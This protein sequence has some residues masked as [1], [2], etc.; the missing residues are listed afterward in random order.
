MLTDMI[1]FGAGKLAESLYEIASFMG[2]QIV[3][4]VDNDEGKWGKRIKG[5]E[6]VS[7]E[8][9]R[10]YSCKIV[11]PD[12]F[13]DVISLQLKK[14][15]YSGTVVRRSELYAEILTHEY[16]REQFRKPDINRHLTYVIDSYFRQSC[17][18]GAESWS[19]FVNNALVKK[20]CKTFFMCGNN[21]RF[22]NVVDDCVHYREDN[23]FEVMKKMID[24]I[25]GNLPCVIF[26]I[27]SIAI[28]AALIVKKLY[29][30]QIKIVMV[31]H[32][33][34]ERIYKN[35]SNMIEGIDKVICISKKIEE[36]CIRSYGIPADKLLYH[37]NPI[38]LAQKQPRKENM[39]GRLRVGFAARLTKLA[40]RTHLL[41]Q[42]V[43]ECFRRGL[44]VEF[45]IAGEGECLEQLQAYV[46]QN[47]LEEKVHLE[48]WVPPMSMIDF[49]R[50]QDIYISISDYEGMSLTMLEA[51]AY[52]AFP[53]VTE[54]SGVVDVVTDG[55]NGLII[56]VEKWL[57]CVDK[58]AVLDADREL[59]TQGS[60]YNIDCI[61]EK[62]DAEKYADWLI[63]T[64][65][66]EG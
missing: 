53:V 4:F 50:H 17:W 8:H 55:K 46:E 1:I 15:D 38:L 59:L 12:Q 52:G 27:A 33:D 9:L 28:Q 31:I 58:I 43:D 40:K 41:P 2:Y 7:P 16:N 20:N 6:V 56:P 14:M 23:Q 61:R 47:H 10:N 32:S 42:V 64:F 65:Q 13:F 34:T 25:I 24:D 11:A 30:E 37:V 66:M 48:G 22:D 63:D 29:P 26:S 3:V 44:D 18:G 19:C 62:C 60:R 39:Q 49:W 57:E 36:T 35:V 45:H 54:V 21:E 5:I 51:M